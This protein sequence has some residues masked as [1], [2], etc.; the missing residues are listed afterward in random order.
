MANDAEHLF[1]A[2]LP[3]LSLPLWS[4]YSNPL[5]IF[6]WIVCVSIMEF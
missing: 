2:Y 1:V 5:P 4:L 6:N 3:P